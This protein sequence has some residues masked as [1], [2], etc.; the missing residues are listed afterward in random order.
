MKKKLFMAGLTLA[1]T[2][3]LTAAVV[4]A[5]ISEEESKTVVY[6]YALLGDTYEAENGLISAKKPD[7]TAISVSEK[8]VFLDWAQGS[9]IF[10]YKNK[11]VNLKVYEAAPEDEI[12]YSGEMPA[13][14]V[15]GVKAAFPA[16]TVK[17]GIVRTDGAPEIGFYE[18]SAV[19][20]HKGEDVYTVKNAGEEFYFTPAEGGIYE[21]NYIYKDVFGRTRGKSFLTSAREEKIVVY[22]GKTEFSV[23]ERLSLSAAYGYYKGESFAAT[24]KAVAP[25][26][27]TKSFNDY[28]IFSEK[29]KYEITLSS[30]I[31]GEKVE[32]SFTAEVGA[33]LSSFVTNKSGFSDSS[34]FINHANVK[35]APEKGLYL[36]CTAAESSFDYN[37]VIDLKKLGKTVPVISFTTNN[38]YGGNISV[39]EVTLTDVYDAKKAVTVRFAKNSDMTATSLGYDN[40]LVRASF[41][42][43]STAFNNYYPLKTDAVA[44]DT[45]FY[46]FWRSEA[47]VNPDKK[48]SPAQA[49]YTMNFSFDYETN[50]IY[51]YGNFS[52]I[53]RPDGNESGVKQ[54]KIAELSSPSLPVAFEGFTTGEVYLSFKVTSGRGDIVIDT[55]GGINYGSVTARDYATDTDVLIKNFDGS[56]PAIVGKN[57]PVPNAESKFISNFT[58][59]VVFGGEETILTG[60]YFVPEKE[61]RYTLVYSGVNPFGVAIEKR[62]EFECLKSAIPIEITYDDGEAARYGEA[63]EIKAPTISGGH[64]KVVYEIFANGE[65]VSALDKIIVSGDETEIKIVARDELGNTAEKIF[66]I[67]TE[68]DAVSFTVDFPRTAIRGESFEFPK[69]TVKYLATGEIL[70]YEIFVNGV[71]AEDGFV[72]PDAKSVT[73]EYR[74]AKGNKE[75]VLN[76]KSAEVRTGGDAFIFEGEASTTDEGTRVKVTKDS[77]VISLPYKL[78]PN[79]L[80]FEF[81]VLA[82]KLDFGAVSFK[83]TGENGVSVKLTVADIEKDSAKLLVN[84]EDAA[85]RIEKRKQTFSSSASEEF[86]GKDYY[87]FSVLYEDFYKATLSG[88]AIQKYIE[89][90]ERGVKFSGFNCGVYADI[91]L[92]N[93]SAGG[94]EIVITKISNQLFYSSSFDYG[95]VVGPALFSKNFR[96]GNANVGKNYKLDVSGLSAFDVITGKA[97]VTVTLTSPSGVKIYENT[98]AA[99]APETVLTE[100]GVYLLK[101]T[102]K[103]GGNVVTNA[104]YRFSVED[105]SAPEI[106]VSEELAKTAK[107]G[108][109]IKLPAASCTDETAATVRVFVTRPDGKVE[110]IE[111][112][113]SFAATEY[114]IKRAGTYR[115]TYVAEDEYGNVSAKIFIVTAEEK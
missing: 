10:E 101:I 24:G 74:T 87:A 27:E 84:G 86:A 6:E 90:D 40:T 34:E 93:V 110:I 60:D 44:W 111:G 91:I 82:E 68:G 102:A 13:E 62:V 92:E 30:E 37:G 53:G 78:S 8:S 12:T 38:A 45:T 16:A 69:A 54:W 47:H 35:N 50:E 42:S 61:G 97:S 25:S 23:G 51:S 77:P 108:D 67:A 43:V 107:V 105:G 57:Y 32:K 114:E 98:A 29:G 106:I 76:L 7:G 1:L 99:T 41:G 96:L 104:N 28:L 3:S 5:D 56:I 95:D 63:Y 70:P 49:T 115:I 59:K 75:F 39:V 46:G 58:R 15:A 88:S 79:G 103:D 4:F 66:K 83:I 11:T 48:Y 2:A 18:V 100:I 52:R 14:T 72:M 113:A 26:G 9:Y 71:K 20:S 17:S 94:A 21:L 85:V 33:S 31:A 55:L 112:G 89:K 19:F 64:G 22:N 65:S 81:I 73:V 80:Y 36:D 109:K